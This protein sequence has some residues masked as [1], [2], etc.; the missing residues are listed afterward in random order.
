M[1]LRKFA[2]CTVCLIAVLAAAGCADGTGEALT[3]TLPTVDSNTTNADGT[4]LKASAPQ[5]PSPSSAVRV[6]TLTPTL[7]W[8]TAPAVR[9]QH[10]ALLRLRDFRRHEQSPRIGSDPRG[11]TRNDLRRARERAAN[12]QDIRLAGVRV[13]RR[14]LRL[15]LGRGVILTPVP[16]PPPNRMSPGRFSVPAA[17]A[18]TSLPVSPTRFRSGSSRRASRAGGPTWSS[19]AT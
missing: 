3:P 8:P 13:L 7:R 16:A 10:P 17:A 5:P 11:V 18:G 4:T 9:P 6:T 15:P 14:S 1:E 2:V 19:C 12:E